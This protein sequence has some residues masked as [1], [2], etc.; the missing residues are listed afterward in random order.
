MLGKD[1]VDLNVFIR[2][3]VS[4]VESVRGFK[5]EK[6]ISSNKKKK[7]VFFSDCIF[8]SALD[9]L[10]IYDKYKFDYENT[11]SLVYIE[12]DTYVYK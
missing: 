6:E 4:Y 10:Y 9:S 12:L 1:F 7:K 5:E 2:I 11:N 8:I 3:N